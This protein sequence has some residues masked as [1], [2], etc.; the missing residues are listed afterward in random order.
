MFNNFDQGMQGIPDAF[1]GEVGNSVKLFIFTPRIH[2][3]ICLRPSMFNFNPGVVEELINAQSACMATAMYGTPETT[4]LTKAI[5]PD[6]IGVSLD[7]SMLDQMWSFVLVF[8]HIGG[9]L[10]VRSFGGPHRRAVLTGYFLEEPVVPYTLKSSRPILNLNSILIFTHE[11]MGVITKHLAQR[12]RDSIS[13]ATN[14]DYVPQLVDAYA[15][16]DNLALVDASTIARCTVS[17]GT[18]KSRILIDDPAVIS[19]K[20]GLSPVLSASCK[21]PRQHMVTIAEAVDSAVDAVSNHNDSYSSFDIGGKKRIGDD[22]FTTFIDTLH[23]HLGLGAHAGINWSLD[24]ASPIS[25]GML[26]GK[27]PNMNVYPI[28]IPSTPCYEVGNQSE[29][30]PHNTFSSMVSSSVSAYAMDLGI[31]GIGFRYDSFT[32]GTFGQRR[33]NWQMMRV[34][35][36]LGDEITEQQLF[37]NVNQF[38]LGMESDLFPVLRAFNGEFSLIVDYDM[39]GSTVVDLHFMDYEDPYGMYEAHNKLGGIISPAVGTL[40][41]LHTNREQFDQLTTLTTSNA[42]GRIPI[43]NSERMVYHDI[44]NI[45]YGITPDFQ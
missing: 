2:G 29:V 26:E 35:S 17:D 42:I 37:G 4:Y 33:G 11:S 23:R 36:F 13:I 25:L 18:S 10:T 39:I 40:N 3:G 6:A 7:T 21:T 12:T 34:S 28:S 24:P 8:D 15:G 38:K 14:N 16:G 32:P 43:S 22:P 19:S 9:S 31:S 41:V 45:G 44:N 30:N 27:F 20:N 5:K 1:K